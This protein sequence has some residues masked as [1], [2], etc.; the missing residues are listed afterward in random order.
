M[1]GPQ[2]V[3]DDAA[4]NMLLESFA[5]AWLAL[6]F[7]ARAAIANRLYFGHT[8]A[9]TGKAVGVSG[10]KIGVDIDEGLVHLVGVLRREASSPDVA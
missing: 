2:D 1:L 3:E 10:R 8:L 7:T 6:P 4:I 9:E 5:K